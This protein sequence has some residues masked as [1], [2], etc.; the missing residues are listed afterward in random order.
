MPAPPAKA[1]PTK[2]ARTIAGDQPR[3][4][5]RPADTPVATHCRGRVSGTT[6][7]PPAGEGRGV[8]ATVSPVDSMPAIQADPAAGAEG[9]AA[10]LR[11]ESGIH[12]MAG[13][14]VALPASRHG[15]ELDR[16]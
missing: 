16:P 12:P 10:R 15:D 4:A 6:P 3:C 11:V 2:A 1:S 14:P 13:H 7:R 9:G 8:S 5:A